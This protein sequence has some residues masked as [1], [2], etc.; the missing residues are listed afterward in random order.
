MTTRIAVLGDFNPKY[1]T[2]HAFNDSIRH[3]V[4]EMD[5]DVQ[6]DW[7][8]TD[9]F[10]CNSAFSTYSGLWIASGSPYANDENVLA[11]IKYVRENKIPT[12]GNCGGFQCMLI[13]YA[14]NVCNIV[15]ADHE[16]TYAEG[17]D[18]I[19]SKLSCSLVDQEEE[20][21]ILDID[22]ILYNIVGG[23]KIKGGYY[24]SYGL[25]ENYMQQLSDAGLSFTAKSQD[26]HWRAF[27]LK[28]HP[29]YV[30][31]LFQP[32]LTSSAMNPNPIIV[33]FIKLCQ[34]IDPRL[35]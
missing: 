32:A 22:S 27:E 15:N 24:C 25:N 7:I 23:P 26:G 1:S 3:I 9:I 20:L 14:R 16:E 6:F 30:A 29:F 19:I 35:R 18:L 4:R 8:G 2:H 11:T 12:F 13:E 34:T 31:T 10:D 21:S 28:S 5:A 33:H 17:K